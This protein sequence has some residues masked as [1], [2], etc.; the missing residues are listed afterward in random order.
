MS[1]VN[2][3]G[4]EVNTASAQL[5]TYVSGLGPALARQ[6]VTWR[7]EN[8]PFLSRKELK[9]VPRLGAMAFQQAA[10]FLRI[11]NGRNPLDASAVHPESYAI[12]GL[13]AND[14]SCSVADLM[15][16]DSLRNRI[17][18]ALYVTE[19]IGIPTLNDILAELAK[20]GRD[21]RE[22]FEVFQ[23][24]EGIAKIED[25]SPGMRLP[26]IVTNITAFGAFV[27]IGVHQ[28]GLVHLSQLADRYVKDPQK[29][30]KVRQP[31]VVT[32]LAVDRERNRIS[33][34]LKK[35][36]GASANSLSL[37]P[38]QKDEQPTVNKKPK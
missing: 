2:A 36:P 14:M 24:A 26:G 7:D 12:V 28:D 8:G 18:L 19:Q 15:R 13:M 9:K 3:I 10:G 35:Q 33:L 38:A 5:L 22:S 4:V 20:P 11:R 31:V 32:V 37:S 6:I 1:C 16:D 25:I 29:V 21:P 23:F 27:D 17:D 34:S 30:L